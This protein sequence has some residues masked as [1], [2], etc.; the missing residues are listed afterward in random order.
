MYIHYIHIT[1]PHLFLN[2]CVFQIF[3]L[4]YF[5]FSSLWLLGLF[6]VCLSVSTALSLLLSGCF[7]VHIFLF[8]LLHSSVSIPNL[9]LFSPFCSI[10][11]SPLLT[12]TFIL[13][14]SI[15][16]TALCWCFCPCFPILFSPPLFLFSLLPSLLLG[17]SP[18]VPVSRLHLSAPT[19]GSSVCYLVSSSPFLCLSL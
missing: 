3:C 8:V 11:S 15:S 1:L 10:L 13:F 14:V 19:W 2:F 16:H 18:H 9:S 12:V 5:S 17:C 4:F 7:P 6:T